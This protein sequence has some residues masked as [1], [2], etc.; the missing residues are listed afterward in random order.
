MIGY[1][2]A[3]SHAHFFLTSR[4]SKTGRYIISLHLNKHQTINQSRHFVDYVQKNAILNRIFYSS[5]IHNPTSYQI[6]CTTKQY[7][8]WSLK[9]KF[10]LIPRF[11][12][13]KKNQSHEHSTSDECEIYFKICKLVFKVRGKYALERV[14]ARH[15]QTVPLKNYQSKEFMKLKCEIM[16][17]MG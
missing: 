16:G 11:Q 6:H 10:K 9:F 5:C 1:Y 15:W 17:Q 14:T 7:C 12:I 13:S 3:N 4:N 2:L 8:N